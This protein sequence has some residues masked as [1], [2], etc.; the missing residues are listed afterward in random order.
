MTKR[1]LE[2]QY[3]F[4]EDSPGLAL[5]RA[6]NAWQNSQRK[7]LKEFDLTHM[8]F[9]LLASL[10]WYESDHPITQRN[11]C[12]YARLDEMM[13]SQV[14]RALEKKSL[15]TRSAHPTDGRAVSLAATSKGIKL[16]NAAIKAVEAVDQRYFGALSDNGKRLVKDLNVLNKVSNSNF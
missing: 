8:Q 11:L 4:A 13:T 3:E 10:V 1:K 9:V 5:W 14:L 15:L 2:S 6:T 16:V 7:A 12:E